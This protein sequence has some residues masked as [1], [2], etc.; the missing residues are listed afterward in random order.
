MG[1]HFQKKKSAGLSLVTTISIQVINMN[2][3]GPTD[4]YLCL[5]GKTFWYFRSRLSWA[6]P[7]KV[8]ELQS[9]GF[10]F[11]LLWGKKKSCHSK[12]WVQ[13]V[14]QTQPKLFTANLII[15]NSMEANFSPHGV[16]RIFL[17]HFF[18]LFR[19]KISMSFEFFIC[20]SKT[21]QI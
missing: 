17:F 20:S 13:L 18:F 5:Q 6:A 16:S 3:V 1:A 2:P 4:K 12:K 19:V 9:V 14:N 8:T 10:G 15:E 11:P 21:R 7:R